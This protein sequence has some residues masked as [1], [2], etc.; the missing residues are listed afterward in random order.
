MPLSVTTPSDRAVPCRRGNSIQSQLQQHL[1]G[2]TS[3]RIISNVYTICSI[4]FPASATFTAASTPSA[5]SALRHLQHLQQHRPMQQHLGKSQKISHSVAQK[6]NL[7]GKFLTPA[8]QQ[9]QS[10]P[11][12]DSI[13]LNSNC[14]NS[15]GRRPPAATIQFSAPAKVLGAYAAAVASRA[16][17]SAAALVPLSL[18]TQPATP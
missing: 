17:P 7:A 15:L 18:S 2:S 9:P 14:S 12:G 1:R 11:P 3:F 4:R 13:S 5:I 16:F 6:K 8:S 10:L